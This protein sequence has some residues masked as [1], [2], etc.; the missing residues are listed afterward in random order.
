[1]SD[2]RLELESRR[3]IYAT[4]RDAP[5]VHLRELERRHEYAKGTLQYHLRHLERAG[6]VE[7]HEDGEFTRYYA[8]DDAFDDE[9][10]AV[11][12]E[13]LGAD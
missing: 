13:G 9:D 2:D 10:R 7:A 5:G 11:Y 12:F 6:L 8:S 1:M 4:I 3:A